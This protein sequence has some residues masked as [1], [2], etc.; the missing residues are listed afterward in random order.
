MVLTWL[1]VTVF[2]STILLW[3]RVFISLWVGTGYYLGTLPTLLIIVANLQLVLIR[4]DASIIDLTLRLNRKVLLG[5]LSVSLSL[6]IGIILVGYYNLGVVGLCLG[7]IIGRAILSIGYPMIVGKFLEISFVS[8][9]TTV[10]RPGLITI[11]LF[12]IA[13]IMDGLALTTTWFGQIGWFSLIF[14]A[15]TTI[16]MAFFLAFYA[17]LPGSQR[18]ILLQRISLILR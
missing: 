15:G 4:N 1:I 7:L 16:I 3:N 13:S 5:A 11:L 8:Q 2:G 6:I 14:L 18:K 12:S 9:L 10:L 17:G